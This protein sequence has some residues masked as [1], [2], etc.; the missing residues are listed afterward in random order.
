MRFAPKDVWATTSALPTLVAG[1]DGIWVCFGAIPHKECGE[2]KV[3]GE[4][5][6]AVRN[7][8]VALSV[9]PDD[10]WAPTSA[11]TGIG[12]STP[13]RASSYCRTLVIHPAVVHTD[14]VISIATQKN[15]VNA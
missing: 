8:E 7:H 9:V 11:H 4:V 3:W 10:L 13:A 1:N 5:L 6:T 2:K 15:G 12:H 14:A